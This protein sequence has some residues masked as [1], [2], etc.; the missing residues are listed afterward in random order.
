[1]RG[2]PA[3]GTLPITYSWAPW[4]AIWLFFVWIF[5][6]RT[7]PCRMPFCDPHRRVRRR[8]AIQFVSLFFALI[9][10]VAVS[11]FF[12]A[13]SPASVNPV[14]AACA[15]GVSLVLFWAWIVIV[16]V[17]AYRDIQ[18]TRITDRTLTLHRIHEAFVAAVLEARDRGDPDAHRRFGDV[19]DDFDDAAERPPERLV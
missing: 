13:L 10:S 1:M 9:A 3:A 18:A 6:M 5:V 17:V 16:I 4:W 11:Y 2:A 19:R 7:M 12:V 14:V 15:L 8:R